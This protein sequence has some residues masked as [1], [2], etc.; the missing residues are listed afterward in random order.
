MF[1]VHPENWGRFR[2]WLIFFKG[3]ETTNQFLLQPEKIE[4]KQRN[5]LGPH[6]IKNSS[7][8]QDVMIQSIPNFVQ[9]SAVGNTQRVKNAVFFFVAD[10]VDGSEV[11][12]H[13]RKDALY[14]TCES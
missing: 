14:K 2:F 11:R 9:E 1:Y 5:N 8:Q 12:D 3:V 6:A 10:T 13:H 7:A 4:W